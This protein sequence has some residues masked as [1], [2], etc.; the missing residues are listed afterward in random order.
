[1]HPPTPRPAYH[2]KEGLAP[3]EGEDRAL[4]R[5]M[6]AGEQEAL[7]LLYDRHSSRVYSL[8]LHLLGSE[9]DA[10]EVVEETFWQAWRQAGR[11]EDGRGSVP[12]WLGMITRSRALDR[13][14]ARARLR[15]D[16]LDA[17]PERSTDGDDAPL[18]GDPLANA[19]SAERSALIRRA[20]EELPPEQRKVVEL[21]YFGGLSQTEIAERTGEPLGTIKTRVRLA[22]RKLKE[23]LSMLREER[24]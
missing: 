21:A 7:G 1:M 11:Y 14:R 23:K 18:A 20:M 9:S 8:A 12:T 5:R 4:V 19:E 16:A 3:E 6:A 17:L 24:R 15:E 13:L 22:I 2:F 10:E